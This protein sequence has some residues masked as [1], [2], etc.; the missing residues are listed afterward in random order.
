M[1]K[2]L[3]FFLILIVLSVISTPVFAQDSFEEWKKQRQ[4][5]FQQFKDERDAK[6]LEMLDEGWADFASTQPAPSY[7]EPKLD[8]IPEAP[9]RPRVGGNQPSSPVIIDIDLDLPD[10]ELDTTPIDSPAPAAPPV[11]APPGAEN[12]SLDFYEVPVNYFYFRNQLV[13]L[14][15]MPNEKSLQNYWADMSETDYE[16]IVER[17]EQLRKEISLNDWG[18]LSA[19]H[20]MAED[21]YGTSG[22]NAILFTWYMMTKADY[23][24]KL[25]Y[26]GAEVYLLLPAQ[27]RIYNTPF[28]TIDNER[29]YVASLD[30]SVQNPANIRTYA[31]SYPNADELVNLHIPNTPKVAESYLERELSFR[32]G[33][34]VYSFS[35]P[36][37][38]NLIA[39]YEYYPHTDLP[40]Y[41]NAKRS[42]QTRNALLRNLAGIIDGKD[43]V[44]A[45]NILMRFTQTAFQ[46]QTDTEQ[47]KR[48]KYMLP[49]ETLYYPYSDCDDRAIMLAFLVDEL[50]GLEVVGL[51]YPRHLATAIK[52]DN[53]PSDG[54]MVRVGSDRYTIADP[55]YILADVGATM[56]QFEGKTPEVI[57]LR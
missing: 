34:E 47:F 7:A 13:R 3:Q 27:T 8:D 37:N 17:L 10:V 50:L 32:Y 48:Q 52:F 55:T 41:H 43:Q 24:M 30:G 42:E 21:M 26:S 56:P 51:L 15:G 36:V 2:S 29:Y 45:A 25:G 4:E 5:Q 20:K 38:R 1:M 39:F 22:N 49:E 11:N 6:F 12:A 14:D 53:P 44:E 16:P 33:D 31:G 18:Y 9:E 54:D 23:K 19:V 35:V 28:Y 57:S 40:V 46:Y